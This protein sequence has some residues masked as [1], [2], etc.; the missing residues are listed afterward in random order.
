MLLAPN[1]NVLANAIDLMLCSSPP[2]VGLAKVVCSH[3]LLTGAGER[4]PK[5]ARSAPAQS[6]NS[7]WATC[8]FVLVPPTAPEPP[9]RKATAASTV[10][11]VAEL[12]I[13]RHEVPGGLERNWAR[14]VYRTHTIR[15]PAVWELGH[16][17]LNNGPNLT[18][19]RIFSNQRPTKWTNKME[20]W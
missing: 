1:A 12:S 20:A 5:P 13:W 6:G 7:S 16:S 4:R 10:L 19:V 11:L 15:A 3:T 8:C 17:V 14:I 18:L 9:R 2:S